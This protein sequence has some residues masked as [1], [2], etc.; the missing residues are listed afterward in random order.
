MTL[1]SGS[2]IKFYGSGGGSANVTDD[3]LGGAINSAEYSPG[4]VGNLFR[5]ATYGT[6]YWYR[7]IYLKNSDTSN[8]YGL[9]RPT[10][11]LDHNFPSGSYGAVYLGLG[12]SAVNGTEQ[13]V[14]GENTAPT[15]VTFAAHTSGSPL[16]FPNLGPGET[17]AF[18]VKMVT[19]KPHIG[20]GYLTLEPVVK[21]YTYDTTTNYGRVTAASATADLNVDLQRGSKITVGTTGKN[22]V[23]LSGSAYLDGAGGA[24]SGSQ[25][26]KLVTYADSSNY[27]GAL[28][29]TSAEGSVT[30]G[31]S[32]GWKTLAYGHQTILPYGSY[33]CNIHTGATD[34]VARYYRDTSGGTRVSGV[35]DTYSNGPADPCAAG[36]TVDSYSPSIFLQVAEVTEITSST[37]YWSGVLTWPAKSGETLDYLRVFRGRT[38]VVNS[39]TN[40]LS[41]DAHGFANPVITRVLN[42]PGTFT[43]E[44][45]DATVKDMNALIDEDTL[46]EFWQGQTRKGVFLVDSYTPE[47]RG[48]QATVNC[49]GL[50][51]VMSWIQCPTDATAQE[52]TVTTVSDMLRDGFIGLSPD[53]ASALT[54]GVGLRYDEQLWFSD[55][56][57]YSIKRDEKTYLDWL[58]EAAPVT[59]LKFGVDKDYF[60]FINDLPALTDDPDITYTIDDNAWDFQTEYSARDIYNR[61]KVIYTGGDVTC[62]DEDSQ[63]TYGVREMPSVTMTEITSSTYATQYGDALLSTTA[64]PQQSII[65]T[66]EHSETT[67]VGMLAEVVG[68]G[69]SREYIGYVQQITWSVGAL[70][71]EVIVGT[72]PLNMPSVLKWYT[73]HS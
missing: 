44:V 29:E 40:V 46:I 2:S 37:R 31:D 33:W 43:F 22:Y 55:S 23:L 21:A 8:T 57:G 27:P 64:A 58:R 54:G 30:K 38:F 11:Y 16:L 15:G 68:L 61:V 65:L 63:D 71:D 1:V 69:D 56:Q 50:L 34:A 62:D 35:S 20:S 73:Y 25:N 66:V 13:T 70:T 18:W 42:D 52:F 51:N 59:G 9:I 53:I 48:Q 72:K 14:A 39:P 49:V 28:K 6:N 26:L 10:L 12:T 3:F 45:P 67:E 19:L 24:A 7:C 41:A 4:L 60:F 5:N 47:F 32:A 36:G 17:K